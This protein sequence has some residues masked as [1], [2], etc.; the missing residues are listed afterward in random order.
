MPNDL[1]TVSST[2]PKKSKKRVQFTSSVPVLPQDHPCIEHSANLPDLCANEN[3]CTQLQRISRLPTKDSSTAACVGFLELSGCSKHLVYLKSSTQP[4][5]TDATSQ[6]LVVLKDLFDES[7]RANLPC[8]GLLPYERVRI[9]KQLA[10]AVLQFEATPWLNNSWNSQE[11]LIK[12]SANA[13]SGTRQDS[14]GPFLDVSIKHSIDSSSGSTTIASRTL[15]RNGL[16]F[17]LGV[18][19]LELAYQRPLPELRKPQDYD[20]HHNQNTDYFTADR[21]RHQASAYLG[22]RY[23]EAARK[24]IQCDFGHD[25]DLSKTGLQEGFYQD[26]I[27]ELEELEKVFQDFKLSI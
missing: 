23:A 8:H 9:A 25:N 21:I 16:L 7:H 1:L 26:V 5:V 10:V 17:N 27:C 11:I 12:G 19:M 4:V 14:D 15:V 13:S 20:R 24:C 22:P 18:M 3:F 2:L 6:S